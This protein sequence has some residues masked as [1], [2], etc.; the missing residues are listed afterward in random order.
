MA[1][2]VS[3]ALI[4]AMSNLWNLSASGVSQKSRSHLVSRSGRK[5]TAPS[6]VSTID[7]MSSIMRLAHGPIERMILPSH[8]T[9]VSS[10]GMCPDVAA[11]T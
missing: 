10:T 11:G 6:T 3:L 4:S 7:L 8:K 5:Y 1:M 2:L 9:R